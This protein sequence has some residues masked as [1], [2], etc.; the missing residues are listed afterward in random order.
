[1]Y[2][3][4]IDKTV[5]LGRY[6]QGHGIEPIEWIILTTRT[7]EQ[8]N[9]LLLMSRYCL[10]IQPY[11]MER[12]W[13]TWEDCT[14]R[15]WLNTEFMNTAF[16]DREK[17]LIREVTI[18]NDDNPILHTYGGNETRD[19]IFLLSEKETKGRYFTD[20]L[21]GGYG[22]RECEA[23]E[24]AKARGAYLPGNGKSWWW[25]RSP[26]SYGDHAAFVHGDGS[27]DGIGWDVDETNFGVRPVLWIDRYSYIQKVAID[28]HMQNIAGID[29]SCI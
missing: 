10:D 3:V 2:N 23:T 19:K 16:T 14:L 22:A 8:E 12:R 11:N 26:G 29:Y 6:E 27:V 9:W 18:T 5:K 4:T 17:N 21:Y 7:V 25:L 20:K 28:T 13:V 15:T 24:Y 1:M